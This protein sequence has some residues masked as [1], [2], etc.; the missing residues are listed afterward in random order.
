MRT[1]WFEHPDWMDFLTPG[2]P[3]HDDKLLER[4]MYLDR[5]AD[6]IPVGS[7]CSMW[8]G[9]SVASRSGASIA[10]A[11]CTSWT[12]ISAACGRGAPRGRT[13][14]STGRALDHRRPP[15]VDCPGGRGDRGRSVALRA[16]PAGR[17]GRGHGAPEAGGALLCSVEAR[18]GWAM[19]PDVAE[20]SI[21]AFFGDGVVHVD[22][23]RWVRT[24]TEAD[25]RDVLKG[26]EILELEPS[27][28]VLA[29][30]LRPRP[31]R[32]TSIGFVRWS[33]GFEII[34]SPHR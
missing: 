22:G 16:R 15:A 31:A 32:S 28:Y 24:Y 34:R 9:A 21:D 20:G 26:L 23:D 5:W 7:G 13:P 10:G 3:G 2:H 30:R 1:W 11:T 14:R 4:A 18:N 6:H 8:A 25:L 19:G 33:I 29:V 17:C 27:H 12:R